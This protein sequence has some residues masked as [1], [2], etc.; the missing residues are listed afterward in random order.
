MSRIEAV[1]AVMEMVEEVPVVVK[2]TD[3]V[4]SAMKV[5][6]KQLEIVKPVQL[7]DTY[8][9]VAHNSNGSF[10]KVDGHSAAFA[11]KGEI[12]VVSQD[13]ARFLLKDAGVRAKLP[14]GTLIEQ[15]G[16]F[17]STKLPSGRVIVQEKI[18]AHQV[19]TTID[20]KELGKD[21]P[22]SYAG[23]SIG[24][25][26]SITQGQK[27]ASSLW[28]RDNTLVGN[29][30]Y[31]FEINRGAAGGGW[32]GS[33][34][35]ITIAQRYFKGPNPPHL[36]LHNPRVDNMFLSAF[37][38]GSRGQM[39]GRVSSRISADSFVRLKDLVSV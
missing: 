12:T 33:Q 11:A 26:A 35:D 1:K 19:R 14:D 4:L 38:H 7:G 17:V 34:A 13:G 3:E 22:F 36:T 25:G 24:D 9:L 20:G 21:L 31:E 8:G 2:F 5:S 27:H 15:E 10:L 16:E 39:W 23:Q 18:N 6:A 29:S 28:L 30:V 37:A 32:R